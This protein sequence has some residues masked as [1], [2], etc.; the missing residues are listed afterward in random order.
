MQERRVTLKDIAKEVGLSVSAVSLTLNGHDVRLSEESKQRIREVAK[1]KNYKAN[2]LAKSL[3]TKRTDTFGLLVPDIEN[4]FFAS[5][6]KA[7]E[8]YSRN[9]GRVLIIV[10]SNDD[11]VSDN[12]L[13]DMLVSREVDG[14]FLVPSNFVPQRQPE[15]KTSRF[16][17]A[18][19]HLS[20][21]Y[22][23][24]DR[25]SEDIDCDKVA[26]DN[27]RGAAMAVDYLVKHGHR[28]II[29]V[30][31]RDSIN[32]RERLSGYRLSLKNHGIEYNEQFVIHSDYHEQGGYLAG[33]RICRLLEP[34]DSSCDTCATAVLSCSDMTTLGIISYFREVGISIPRDCSL[35]SYDNSPVLSFSDPG[36][37]AVAQDIQ[38]LSYKAFETL[39]A[40]INQPKAPFSRTILTPSLVIRDSV[41]SI[42]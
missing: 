22:V 29:C 17:S 27:E 20:V 30:A 11:P 19:R 40:R 35:I 34:S 32:G 8:E 24:V 15:V 37:T 9:T 33:S 23:L 41:L 36:I 6:A 25:I 10:N 31:N 28:G 3:V 42:S 2:V 39:I 5:L 38:G 4:P 21:P 12:R 26:I 14:L 7:L 18:L 13:L 1:K 16:A